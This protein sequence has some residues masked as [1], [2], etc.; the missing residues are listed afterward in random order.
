MQVFDTGTLAPI[1]TLGTSSVAGSDTAH[2]NLPEDAEFDPSTGQILVADTGNQRVQVFD[3]KSFDYVTTLGMTGGAESDNGHFAQPVTAAF[4]PAT[5]LVLVADA[6][7]NDRVQVFDAMTYDYVLTLG[8]VG[9]PGPGITQFAAPR[10]ISTDPA[11][12]RIFIGDGANQRVQLFSVAPVAT[13]ASVLPGSRSVQ[14]GSPATIFAS[15]LNMAPTALTGCQIALPVTAPAGLSLSYQT[16]DPATNALT[17]IANS[18]AT[19]PGANGVQSFLITLQGTAPVSVADLPLDFDCLGNAPAAVVPGVDTIDLTL[20]SAPIA[21]IIALA[22]TPT[23]NGIIAVPTHGAAA[24]AVASSN[25]GDTSQ[26]T[27]PGDTGSA[28]LPLSATL[29]QSNPSTGACLATPASSVTL[30]D[31]AGATP[32][33]SVFLQANGTI[34]FAPATS[35]VFLRFKDAGGG[36][37]GSTS[38]AVETQ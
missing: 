31:P 32:T 18:P 28:T 29:C 3:A 35:R 16:T 6:G 7:A 27:V 17:G 9:T 1:A 24:F 11:H 30:N 20:S 36:L 13:I 21:D 15:V 25:A 10:G 14:L 33:F 4:D 22:A 12:Q 5:N 23:D 26:I 19:I 2:L 8:T 38:V 34:P 37:H